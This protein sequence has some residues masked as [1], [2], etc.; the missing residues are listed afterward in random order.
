MK[1]LIIGQ[2]GQ[3]AT[4]LKK[5][6]PDDFEVLCPDRQDFD[7][8]NAALCHHYVL[9]HKPQWV[10]NAGAYTNVDAAED[11]TE[12]VNIVNF[13][14]PVH[15]ASALQITGGKLLQI[16]TDYVFNGRSKVPYRIDN[17]LNPINVYGL[18]KAKAEDYIKMILPKTCTAVVRTSWLYSATGVNFVKTM[19]RLFRERGEVKVVADQYGSPT[20]AGGLAAACWAIVQY[21]LYGTFH[22]TDGAPMSWADFADGIAEEAFQLK[23]IDKRPVI[24]RV[25][26]EDYPCKAKRPQYSVLDCTEAYEYLGQERPDWRANLRTVLQEL[27]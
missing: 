24:H 14:S 9:T 2:H 5:R 25:A 19:L 16:S 17:K 8:E 18:S 20:W 15:I 21:D 26:T 1:V 6:I 4:E 11:D 7:L 22:W 10:I 23:L 3:L 27:V 13:E 12:L